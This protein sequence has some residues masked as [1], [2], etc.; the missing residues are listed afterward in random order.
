MNRRHWI[1]EQQRGV[2]PP[3]VFTHCG[4]VG[5]EEG[6]NEFSTIIGNRFEAFEKL[7]DVNCKQCLRSADRISRSGRL[8]RFAAK[9]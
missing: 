9:S 4:R 3:Q 7:S 2:H 5:W 1:R 8:R 6:C